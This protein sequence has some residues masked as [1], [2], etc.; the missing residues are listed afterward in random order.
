MSRVKISK[1][2][3]LDEYFPK[4]LYLKYA[5]AGR[6]HVLEWRLSKMLV[7]SDQMLRKALG[8]LTINN[9]WD[10]GPR[11][12][13]GFR[14]TDSK[15][16]SEDSFHSWAMASDKIPHETDIDDCISYAK[17]NYEVLGIGGLEVRA[18]WL[19]TDVRNSDKLIVFTP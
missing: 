18:T 16:Y 15:Y 13:S 9:W 8:P 4:E 1:N 17:N 19:H 2:F 10:G 11:N 7:E 6:L 14:T 3:Y 5:N 12:W